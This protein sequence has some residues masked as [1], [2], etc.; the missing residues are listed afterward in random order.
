[1]TDETSFNDWFAKLKVVLMMENILGTIEE[2]DSNLTIPDEEEYKAI[3]RNAILC[4][5]NATHLNVVKD[6]MDWK[7]IVQKLWDFLETKI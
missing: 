7:V 6:S 5:L 1:M 3:C 2:T 4:H